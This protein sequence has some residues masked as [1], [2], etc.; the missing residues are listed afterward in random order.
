MQKFV[1]FRE[2]VAIHDTDT[3]WCMCMSIYGV[4]A[5]YGVLI[6]RLLRVLLSA[7]RAC[8]GHKT[9]WESTCALF[10]QLSWRCGTD[11]GTPQL[12]ERPAAVSAGRSVIWSRLVFRPRAFFFV[13]PPQHAAKPRDRPA[14]CCM[15]PRARQRVDLGRRA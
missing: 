1:T 12:H 13:T 14:L 6:V 15:L 9:T 4:H 8:W 7:R 2:K 3:L 10:L 11:T 5:K